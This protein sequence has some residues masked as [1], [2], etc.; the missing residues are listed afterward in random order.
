[1]LKE[2]VLFWQEMLDFM[3]ILLLISEMR[4]GSMTLL[5][6]NAR[7]FILLLSPNKNEDLCVFMRRK[8]MVSVMEILLLLEKLKE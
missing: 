4:I 3:D 1:M 5:V 7:L 2:E 8:N 6:K